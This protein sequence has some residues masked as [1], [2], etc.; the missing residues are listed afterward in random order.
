MDLH[1]WHE[2]D[3]VMFELISQLDKL[4]T[5]KIRTHYLNVMDRRAINRNLSK[6]NLH[7]LI[8]QGYEK[9]SNCDDILE[10]FSYM[11]NHL[12]EIHLI[13]CQTSNELS[14][15]LCHTNEFSVYRIYN[16][17]TILHR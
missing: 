4:G 9:L 3:D 7:T 14:E 8:L 5:L 6:M 10:P 15:S 1:N 16:E 13:N 2:L 12:Q 11:T 17:K